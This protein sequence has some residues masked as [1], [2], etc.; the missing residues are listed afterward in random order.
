[1]AGVDWG[2]VSDSTSISVGCATCRIEVFLDRF[3]GVEYAIQRD[4][5]RAAVDRWHADVVAESNAMGLPNIEA[6]R[7][8]GVAVEAFETTAITKPQLID[9]LALAFERSEWKWLPNETAALELEAY[10]MKQNPTTGRR[11]FSAPDDGHDDTVIARAL[12]LR[13]ATRGG[14]TLG[15]A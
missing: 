13:K 5:I 12:M 9:N 7:R 3:T 2:R 1:V 14:V 10:E 6:L 4:R 11:S 8:D 15:I